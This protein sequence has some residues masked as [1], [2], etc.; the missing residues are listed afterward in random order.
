MGCCCSR[1]GHGERGQRER[2]RDR[3]RERER[4][5]ERGVE[6]AARTSVASQRREGVSLAGWQY[7][8]APAPTTTTG[9]AA[10]QQGGQAAPALQGRAVHRW[11]AGNL[12]RS[13]SVRREAEAKKRRRS[14][15]QIALTGCQ[16]QIEGLRAQI[17]MLRASKAGRRQTARDEA[18]AGE[19]IR[20]R[21]GRL[22]QLH[23]D[24]NKLNK[25]INML[26]F[27]VPACPPSRP[28]A[29]SAAA[30]AAAEVLPTRRRSPTQPTTDKTSSHR[31]ARRPRRGA[32]A[33]AAAQQPMDE[34]AMAQQQQ[35]T[36]EGL[37]L[38]LLDGEELPRSDE[39]RLRHRYESAMRERREAAA[40]AGGEDVASL[41]SQCRRTRRDGRTDP[42][43]P[44]QAAGTASRSRVA[45]AAT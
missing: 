24:I 22:Q 27:Q 1:P 21:E 23:Q 34:A 4:E 14:I 5:G 13:C 44:S 20:Q 26:E 33:A 35:A 7:A 28:A 8:R 39:M 30:A 37:L 19:T 12:S 9:P 10:E 6:R 38:L 15:A 25:D 36:D 32:G 17:E 3:E 16:R 31:S 18:S 40:A 43:S 11:E 45:D 2:D 29:A 42:E 41:P